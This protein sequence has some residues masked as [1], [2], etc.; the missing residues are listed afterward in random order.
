MT[1]QTPYETSKHVNDDPLVEVLENYVS[2][3]EVAHLLCAARDQL[4]RAVVSS[5]EGGIESAGRT[6]QNCW[7]KHDHDPV[8][9]QLTTRI[10]KLVGIPLDRAE[11][12]QV[13]HYG[14]GQEYAPHFDAWDADTARGQRCMARGGQRLVTCLIYLNDVSEGGGTC[15]PKLDLEVRA[16]K[17]R[18]VIFHNCHSGTNIRHPDSLHGGMPVLAG[19]KWA[20]NL[21]FRESIYQQKRTAP[22]NGNAKFGRVI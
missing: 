5:S 6:G 18:M 17:G 9:D 22:A 2:D 15:F 8:I 4:Q 3:E 19:E 14:H 1:F 13:V 11:S 10:S 20:C 21:W 16:V 12:I 7:V